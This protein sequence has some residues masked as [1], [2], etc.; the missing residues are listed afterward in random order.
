LNRL[1]FKNRRSSGLTSE[2][3]LKILEKQNFKCALTNVYLTC[4]LIK[5]NKCATNAS[6]DRLDAGGKYVE[7][8]IQL[9]CSAVNSF[10]NKLSIQEF[11]WWC[12]A[13]VEHDNKGAINV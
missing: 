12:R 11:K 3:L 8:N 1:T 10:R 13:V 5:G 6:I 9:V 2:V 4:N 7:D